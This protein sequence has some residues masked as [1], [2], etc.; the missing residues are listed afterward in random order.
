MLSKNLRNR[1]LRLAIIVLISI[2]IASFTLAQQSLSLGMGISSDNHQSTIASSQILP[3]S[4]LS[5]IEFLQFND[6]GLEIQ[7]LQQQL[8]KLGYDIEDQ[9]PGLFDY[10]T[11]QAVRQFQ[12]SENINID[13]LVGPITLSRLQ[14]KT[15]LQIR[16]DSRTNLSTNSDNSPTDSTTTNKQL[17]MPPDIQHILDRGKLTVA[18]LGRDTPP[19]FML[20]K[21]GTLTGSD[22][23]MATD[24]ADQLDV[25]LE[26]NRDST[27][28]D[29]VLDKVYSH[30]V[31]LAISKIS[32]TLKR[33][34]QA[35]FSLPYLEMRQGLLVDRLQLAK[36]AKGKNMEEVLRTLDGKIGVIQGS[37]Y[38]DFAKHKFPHA[39]VVEFS[40]WPD[41]VK[42]VTDGIILAAY[43]DELEVKKIVLGKPDAAL[44]FQTVALIDTRDPIAI[45]LPWDS[46]HLLSFVNQY[47]DTA[48]IKHTADSL[49]EKY[50][51]YFNAHEASL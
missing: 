19:F 3:A 18:I 15:N 28:F 29:E 46:G 16:Q 35:R 6:Q 31:D 51:D 43:R 11:D 10:K 20:G 4:S 5:K 40:S 34:Q 49:L 32:R 14:Q 27:T 17:S 30:E 38:V 41:V 45:V 39:K 8:K 33:G 1:K 25:K 21:D 48:E 7:Q 42:A 9:T 12:K 44:R 22:I 13:G 24:I 23:Q 37:S 36:K 2:G 50:S 26:F 47:I